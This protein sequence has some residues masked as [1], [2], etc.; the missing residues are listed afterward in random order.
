MPVIL[1][2]E[3]HEAWLSN[4]AGKEALVPVPGRSHA[5]VANQLARKHS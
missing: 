1:A 5:S 3:H 2:E 4:E